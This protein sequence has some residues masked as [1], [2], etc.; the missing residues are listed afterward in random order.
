LVN[1]SHRKTLIRLLTIFPLAALAVASVD[2]ASYEQRS[3][4]I[5]D[6]ILDRDGNIH[7]YSGNNL[8]PDA[9]LRSAR[10]ISANLTGHDMSRW[11]LSGKN[12]TE[13]NL[14]D[15]NL[16]KMARTT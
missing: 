2:A 4:T 5:I 16:T 13:V 14:T 10:T 1:T 15:A 3:G 11:D 8:E 9:N 7:A 12:L 6:P